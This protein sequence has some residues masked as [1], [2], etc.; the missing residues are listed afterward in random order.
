[1]EDYHKEMEIAI[2]M[3]NMVEDRETIMTRFFNGL[4][5]EISNVVELHH[6]MEL[7]DIVY[8]AMKVEG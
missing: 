2:I 6:Y 1:M 4:T 8:M 7:K 3:V 5:R